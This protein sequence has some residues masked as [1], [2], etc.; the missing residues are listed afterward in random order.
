[1]GLVS[2]VASPRNALDTMITAT[3]ETND[4]IVVT[5][6]QKDFDGVETFNPLRRG[7]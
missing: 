4:C 3:A 5:D 6:D 7:G 1:M 2:V